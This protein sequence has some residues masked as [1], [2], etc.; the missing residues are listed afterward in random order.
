MN[1]SRETESWRI[2]SVSPS[3]RET[4]H[5]TRSGS[6]RT[7]PPPPRERCLRGEQ[8]PRRA[9]RRGGGRGRGRGRS[10]SPGGSGGGGGTALFFSDGV[11]RKSTRQTPSPPS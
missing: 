10:E 5:G 4:R 9:E 8:K 6:N 7:R 11:K 2:D 3:P 1:D